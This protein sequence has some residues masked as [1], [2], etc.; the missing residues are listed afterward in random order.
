MNKI[1]LRKIRDELDIYL[2][3]SENWANSY[4]E[5]DEQFKNLLK[6]KAK[7]ERLF[8]NYFHNIAPKLINKIGLS[9]IATLKL[10]NSIII[11]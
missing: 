11:G 6:N 7:L 9:A 8:K 10:M 4:F 2:G 1:K 3:A 5:H